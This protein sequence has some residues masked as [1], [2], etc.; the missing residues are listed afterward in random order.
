MNVRP[1]EPAPK[2][3]ETTPDINANKKKMKSAKNSNLRFVV[4][5]FSKYPEI[6]P[7]N[8]VSCLSSY[9]YGLNK[10]KHSSMEHFEGNKSKLFTIS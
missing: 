6:S 4:T 1:P 5:L 10:M 8:Q 9:F 2:N 7:R 3:P